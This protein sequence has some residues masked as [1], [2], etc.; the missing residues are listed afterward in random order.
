MDV[1][2][3]I[4]EIV[5]IQRRAE[6]RADR[7]DQ[8]ANRA[9]QRADRADQRGDR[10]DARIAKLEKQVTATGNLVRKGIDLIQKRDAATNFKINALIDGQARLEAAMQRTDERFNS[11]MKQLG[12]RIPNGH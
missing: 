4:R 12:R 8:R 10:F 3:V 9:D 2:K 5:E 6:L 11:W 7:A 1:E